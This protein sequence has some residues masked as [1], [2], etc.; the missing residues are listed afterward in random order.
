MM[1][2]TQVMAQYVPLHLGT[3]NQYPIGNK[4]VSAKVYMLFLEKFNGVEESGLFNASKFYDSSFMTGE[5]LVFLNSQACIREAKIQKDDHKKYYTYTLIPGHEEDIIDTLNSQEVQREFNN[6]YD[7]W[8]KNPTWSEVCDYWNNLFS[9]DHNY[10]VVEKMMKKYPNATSLE[11][12]MDCSIDNDIE[13]VKGKRLCGEGTIFDFIATLVNEVID[14]KTNTWELEAQDASSVSIDSWEIAL[15]R[16]DNV[17]MNF[18]IP[19]QPFEKNCALKAILGKD[20]MGWQ[21]NLSGENMKLVMKNT[22]TV[23]AVIAPPADEKK[24][25]TVSSNDDTTSDTANSDSEKKSA[26]V[27]SSDGVTSDTAT[28]DDGK[29]LDTVPS[30]DEKVQE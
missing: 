2:A 28:S 6:W 10:D 12:D 17:V 30:D 20:V 22:R 3:T 15:M 19:S 23:Y 1:M 9:L 24:S 13:A 8:M 25:A 21:R 14:E 27:P 11:W 18:V 7:E 26:T 4:D 5:E 16:G 29:T